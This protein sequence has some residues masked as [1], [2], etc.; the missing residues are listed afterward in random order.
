MGAAKSFSEPKIQFSQITEGGYVA[1]D[2]PKPLLLFSPKTSLD[3]ELIATNMQTEGSSLKKQGF[4]GLGI[5][6]SPHGKCH[7]LHTQGES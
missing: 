1:L 7:L 4:G 3:N 2:H 6:A 5:S